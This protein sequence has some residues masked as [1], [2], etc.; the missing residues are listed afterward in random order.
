VVDAAGFRRGMRQL[1]AAVSVIT[2]EHDGQRAGMTATSVSS[3]TA[4]PPQLG[5][6]INRGNAS[7]A[8]VVGSRRFSVNVLSH[9]QAEIAASFAGMLGLQ[10]EAR[11]GAGNATWS[12]LETGAP[13]LDG[14]AATFDCELVQEVELS[15]HVLMVGLVRAVSVTPTTM[16][17]LFMDGT[18]ASLVRADI[19]AL[20]S[21]EAIIGRV[22]AAMAEAQAESADAGRQFARFIKRFAEIY[23][24]EVPVLRQFFSQHAIAPASRLDAL[25]ARKRE[26]EGL[27]LDLLR[28][29]RAAGQ[30][31]LPDAATAA[32]AIFGMFGSVHRWPADQAWEPESVAGT[33]QTLAI[34]VAGATPP[35]VRD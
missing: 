9:E 34:V 6:A 2:T 35:S 21:Y 25:A 3:L 16:P 26:I 31:D 15:S 4:E 10:G 7:Y 8:A 32:Q 33:L 11:F 18:W 12:T 13:V 28:R 14:T 17:L 1:A 27:L 5:V 29:G 22:G 20:D 23:A 24:A 30:F 19:A